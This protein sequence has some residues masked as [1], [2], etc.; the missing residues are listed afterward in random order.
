MKQI[1]FICEF[2]YIDDIILNWMLIGYFSWI[3][4]Q[5]SEL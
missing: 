1:V 4:S 5:V 3:L 2:E